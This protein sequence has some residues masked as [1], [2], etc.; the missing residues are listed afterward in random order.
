MRDLTIGVFE[1]LEIISPME[2][3]KRVSYTH[4]TL[5]GV[6]L[7]KYR[8]ILEEYIRR[9]SSQEISGNSVN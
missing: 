7:K 4:R 8:A 3:D 6:A 1:N 9:K 2:V 5:R